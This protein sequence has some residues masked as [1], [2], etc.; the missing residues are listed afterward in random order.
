[1]FVTR[2]FFEK[3]VEQTIGVV[4]KDN[5]PWSWMSWLYLRPISGKPVRDQLKIIRE[6]QQE[7]KNKFD[8]LTQ[9]LGLE[10]KTLP[11]KTGFFKVKTSK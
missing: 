3:W 9:K 7:L 2:K 1:M 5:D 11:E 6:E 8:L 4:E 10:F